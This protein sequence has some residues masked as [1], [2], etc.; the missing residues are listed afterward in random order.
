MI[1]WY[2]AN[3]ATSKIESVWSSLDSLLAE[4]A[5]MGFG[6]ALQIES[7]KKLRW[8]DRADVSDLVRSNLKDKRLLQATISALRQVR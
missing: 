6:L 1:V 7:A 4:Y 5:L 2:K 3:L 8:Y